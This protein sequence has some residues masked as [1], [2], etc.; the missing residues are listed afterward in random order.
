MVQASDVVKLRELTG[1]GMMDCKNALEETGGDMEKAAD[2]LRKKGI[3]KA[4]K[5][6][7]KVAAEG[8][9]LV[10]T[11]GNFGVVMELN[12]ETDFVA[13]NDGFKQTAAEFLDYLLE[14]RPANLDQALGQPMGSAT[15]RE[16]LESATAKIG[17]KIFLRRFAVLEKGGGETFGEYIH[18]GGKIAVLVLLSG[19]D[20]DLAREIAMQAA[21]ANPRYLDR[22]EVPAADLEREKAI[23]ADQLKA[24]GKPESMIENILRGKLEKFYEENCLIDQVYIKDESKKVRDLLGTATIKKFIRFELGEGIEKEQKNF[25]DEVSEQLG[26]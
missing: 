21:A 2:L 1:A 12:C 19:A 7:G 26:G 16:N 22:S 17:E 5:R 13:K 20:A 11:A 14:K 4:A 3:V 10:K 15:V 8:L 25:A 23:H 9:V 6:A 18:M 24:Q